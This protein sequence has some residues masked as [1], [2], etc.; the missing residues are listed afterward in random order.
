[1]EEKF[2]VLREL[3]PENLRSPFTEFKR[4]PGQTR[5]L[6]STLKANVSSELYYEVNVPPFYTTSSQ[7]SSACFSEYRSFK[8][9]KSFPR[10]IQP[11][12]RLQYNGR[13]STMKLFARPIGRLNRSRV[14]S[15][16]PLL[17]L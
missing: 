15:G 1:M 3:L 16:S 8:R 17:E 12:L 10:R 2:I 14:L 11:M 6:Y 7:L 13:R 5:T 9:I 4:T